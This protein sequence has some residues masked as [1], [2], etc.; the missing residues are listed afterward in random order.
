M[1]YVKLAGCIL[2]LLADGNGVYARSSLS[3]VL[4][5]IPGKVQ[6]RDRARVRPCGG[7]NDDS[8]LSSMDLV[9]SVRLI[10]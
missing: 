2:A 1:S 10:A 8:L 6:P 5:R 7:N 3:D 4:M 9:R